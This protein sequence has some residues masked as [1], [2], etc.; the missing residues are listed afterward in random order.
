MNHLDNF[1]KYNESLIIEDI[2]LTEGFK[3]IKSKVLKYLKRG[4]LTAAILI[5]LLGSVSAEE[6]IEI[7]NLV[8]KENPELYQEM[9]DKKKKKE[10]KS[11]KE[12]NSFMGFKLGMLKDDVLSKLK[13]DNLDYNLKDFYDEIEYKYEI[14]KDGKEENKIKLKFNNNILVEIEIYFYKYN[15]SDAVL[16][17]KSVQ[18][19]FERFLEKLDEI[20][21]NDINWKGKW[22]SKDGKI[23]VKTD[24]FTISSIAYN[25]LI[26]KDN[27][28]KTTKTKN[29]RDAQISF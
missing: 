8:N 12:L 4:I 16:N 5:S 10:Q 13:S 19:R 11:V 24:S 21:N 18:R 25:V 17:K 29:T 2:L 22:K 7:L 14:I 28:V 23:L 15:M 3:D 1:Q 6:K 26:I 9:G 20:Y 27:T